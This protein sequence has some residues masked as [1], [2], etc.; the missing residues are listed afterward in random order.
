MAFLAVFVLSF[1]ERFCL[2]GLPLRL[3]RSVH[4]LTTAALAD[5]FAADGETIQQATA[6]PLAE[7]GSSL[8]SWPGT[9]EIFL[10]SAF[11]SIAVRPV[12]C[13]GT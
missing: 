2:A 4:G 12:R 9:T 11:L 6:F 7:H 1:I 10:S 8:A 13:R 3:V 5:Q